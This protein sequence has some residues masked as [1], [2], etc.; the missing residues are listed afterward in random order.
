MIYKNVNE[1]LKRLTAMETDKLER[2]RIAE[3]KR[4]RKEDDCG[5]GTPSITNGG[6]MS[7]GKNG[8]YGN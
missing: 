1:D 2:L 3:E 8:Q 7:S 6:L 4:N 5:G